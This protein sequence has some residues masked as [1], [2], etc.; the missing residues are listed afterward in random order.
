MDINVLHECIKLA[1]DGKITFQESMKRLAE[2]GVERYYTDLVRFEKTNYNGHGESYIDELPLTDTP[3][4]ADTFSTQ[5]IQAALKS[6]QGGEIAYP[7]FLRRIMSAGVANY[8][9]FFKSHKVVYTG[10]HGETHV[11]TFQA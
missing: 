1:F 10:R 8:M 4:I 2:Q 5:D 7:E 6:I 3:E 11:E 9:V